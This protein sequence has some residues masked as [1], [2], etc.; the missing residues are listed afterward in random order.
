VDGDGAAEAAA[1]SRWTGIREPLTG[2]WQAHLDG[3][4]AR[5]EAIAEIFRLIR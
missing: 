1:V 4:G 2:P 3:H 5:D